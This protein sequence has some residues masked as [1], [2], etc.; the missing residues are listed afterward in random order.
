MSPRIVGA[1]REYTSARA[2]TP[3]GPGGAHPA[4]DAGGCSL[5]PPASVTL[6]PN[7]S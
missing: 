4:G 7:L 3:A 2:A 6:T 1:C 5:E